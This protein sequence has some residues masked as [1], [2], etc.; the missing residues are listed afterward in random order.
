[1]S[2][3]DILR[4]IAERG[5]RMAQGSHPTFIDIFQH[6]LDE[7]ARFK[8][9]VAC[10]PVALAD[11]MKRLDEKAEYERVLG[12]AHTT[13]K[14]AAQVI[15]TQAELIE[16][17]AWPLTFLVACKSSEPFT[18]VRSEYIT[19]GRKALADCQKRKGELI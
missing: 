16:T 11:L 7:L 14:E 4:R 10:E 3:T 1:M 18:P 6:M 9:P 13:S 12:A 2:D 5:L 8:A 19:A 17:L 15:R